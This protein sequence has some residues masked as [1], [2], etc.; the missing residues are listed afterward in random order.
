MTLPAGTRDGSYEIASPFS[1]SRKT[2]DI[3]VLEGF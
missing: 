2:G 1:A 3:Y